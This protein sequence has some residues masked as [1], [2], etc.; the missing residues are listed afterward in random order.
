[1]QYLGT[2]MTIQN[3]DDGKWVV[4]CDEVVVTDSGEYVSFTVAVPRGNQ[5]VVEVQQEA[6]QRAIAY[7]QTL[8]KP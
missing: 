4:R 1:M 3:R 6:I 5:T 8:V 7:L 2:P